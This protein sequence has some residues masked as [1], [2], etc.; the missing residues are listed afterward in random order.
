MLADWVG[1]AKML[2]N[3]QGSLAD[4]HLTNGD[5]PAVRQIATPMLVKARSLGDAANERFALMLLGAAAL[6]SGD[7]KTAVRYFGDVYELGVRT[8]DNWVRAMARLFEGSAQ[9]HGLHDARAAEPLL[10]QAVQLYG[11]VNDLDGQARCLIEL[12]VAYT[13]LKRFDDGR[14]ALAS[15]LQ[16]AQVAGRKPQMSSIFAKSAQLELDA[17]QAAAALPLAQSAT[18]LAATVDIAGNQFPAWHVLAV[19]LD[20]AGQAE[21]AFAAHEK[22][23]TTL[24]DVLSR[25]G[26]DAARDG[27]LNVGRTRE[28]F[29]DAVDHCLRTGRIEKAL[30]WLELSRD[31]TLRRIFDPSKLKAQDLAARAALDKIRQAEQQVAASKKALQE[32][33]AKPEAERNHAVVEAL[34]K[35]VAS[36]DREFRQLMVQLNAKNPRMYQALSIK[37]ENVRD[38]QKS[39][40]EGTVVVQYFAA[41]DALYAF[42]ITR[43]GSR[44]K[45]IKVEVGAAELDKAIFG[46]RDT[47]A[48][49]N[50]TVRGGKR[51]EV[52]GIDPT[53][54]PARNKELG[55]KLYNWLLAPIASEIAGAQTVMVVPYGSLYY[56]PVHALET[57]D[58]AGKPLYAIEK[59]RIGYLSAATRFQ[60]PQ[61]GPRPPRTLL[62]F[63]NPD[64]SLPGARA[65]VERLQ[66]DAFPDAKVFYEKDATKARFEQL[67]QNY[68]MVHFA[69]HGI[70]AT[71]ATKSHL[72]MADAPLT[73]FDIHGL[74][75]LD[76]KTDLVVLS[77]C[78]TALQM[79]KSSGEELISVASAFANAGAPSLVASLWEVDDD[80]TAELMTEFYRLLKAGKDK[81]GRPVD[82]LEALRQ[83]QLHV[84]RLDK[85]G[86]T[87]YSD[88]AF[89][90]GFQL[91]GE[92]R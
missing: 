6:D 34:G 7:G 31:A 49:R 86:A 40:P 50:P 19:A 85:A 73:V 28:V 66:R 13:A 68:R 92:Y 42:V 59:Q 70:L 63:A 29:R 81:E 17:G 25:S 38:L 80:A 5:L 57:T 58:A 15:A 44:P 56:L 60:P 75:S 77:A 69:T 24:V 41:D 52:V 76:G 43:D 47:V 27:S 54:A 1:N 72:K 11:S 10:R 18:D 36:N 71:D 62:A 21:R 22:A 26:G 14:R 89:W 82:T 61:T 2:L 33:L 79:G 16:L 74:E 53:A 88:P 23:V 12:G 46:W 90:A 32:E 8:G 4:L 3:A 78:E 39:I 87:P 37:A 9:L 51:A 30:E 64:G 20:K 35:V 83:A 67:A 84:L 45:A 55:K 65:E 91:I 48:A